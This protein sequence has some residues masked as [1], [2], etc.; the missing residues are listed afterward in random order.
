MRT[1]YAFIRTDRSDNTSFGF[2][3]Y[4]EIRKREDETDSEDEKNNLKGKDNEILV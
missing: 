4:F 2:F 3:A 1:D